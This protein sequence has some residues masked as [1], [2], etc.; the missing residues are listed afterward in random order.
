[1]S[2]VADPYTQALDSGGSG[3]YLRPLDEFHTAPAV[4]LEV[5]RWCAPADEVDESIL[6]R[7]VGPVL[8]V[9]CGPGRLTVAAAER[10]MLA[11]GVD[12]TPS[13]VKRTL[14]S[15][16]T[17]LCRSVFEPLPAEGRWSTVLLIDGNV[18]IGGDPLTLLRRCASLIGGDGRVLV[19]VDSTDVDLSYT[20][21]LVDDH[22]RRSGPFPWARVGLPALRQ[23]AEKIGLTHVEQW[24]VA[25]RAFCELRRN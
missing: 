4:P 20:A 16:G 11:L 13:A 6:T 1:V 22:G 14:Q 5:S 23:C 10:G 2:S 24:D 7:C 15:G 18:G 3:L 8:D 25:N 9:G 12:V 17:A 21:Y 19:E